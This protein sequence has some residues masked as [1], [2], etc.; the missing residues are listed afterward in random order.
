MKIWFWNTLFIKSV[1]TAKNK[2][3]EIILKILSR[4]TRG[5]MTNIRLKVKYKI[6]LIKH[7]ITE[8]Y[9]LK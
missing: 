3:N 6:T 1:Q 4:A 2:F 8:P 7:H 5:S 9:V